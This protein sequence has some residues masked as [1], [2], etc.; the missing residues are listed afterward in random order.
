M[1]LAYLNES[2]EID[3]IKNRLEKIKEAYQQTARTADA[4]NLLWSNVNQ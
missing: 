1:N 2:R 3:A 4:E